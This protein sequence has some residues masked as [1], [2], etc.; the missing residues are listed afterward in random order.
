M[1]DYADVVWG[2]KNNVVLMNQIQVLQNNAARIILDLPKYASATQALDQLTWKPLMAR[3]SFHRRVLM[4]KCLNGLVNLNYDFRKNAEHGYN[5]RGSEN[6]RVPKVKTNWGKQRFI[7]QAVKD[8]NSVPEHVKQAKTL[9]SF[10]N[11][12]IQNF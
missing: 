8:W 12:L 11:F 1:F 5:T 3:R 2:D 7:V 10:K 4:Y 9:T 6:I